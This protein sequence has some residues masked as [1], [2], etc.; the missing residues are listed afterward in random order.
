MRPCKEPCLSL[1]KELPIVQSFS[2]PDE[3]GAFVAR[4][5]RGIRTPPVLV[6]P[7][8]RGSSSSVST[9]Q[10]P[11]HICSRQNLGV[12]FT[13]LLLSSRHLHKLL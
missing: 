9:G 1:S 8:G 7:A 6:P 10:H 11:Q 12:C 2:L 3:L 4:F 13:H 5:D